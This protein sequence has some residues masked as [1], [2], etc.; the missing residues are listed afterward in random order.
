MSVFSDF[1]WRLLDRAVTILSLVVTQFAFVRLLS[2]ENYGALSYT[3]AIVAL[4]A[5]IAKLGA[6]GVVTKALLAEPAEADR[7]LGAAMAWRLI[8]GLTSVLVVL[9][10]LAVFPADSG[11][12]CVV[13]LAVSQALTLHTVLDFHFDAKSSFGRLAPCRLAITVLFTITK[14]LAVLIKPDVLTLTFV[15]AIE[16]LIGSVTSAW[17][18]RHI[19]GYYVKLRFDKGALQ[20]LWSRASWIAAAGVAE[21]IYLKIDVL[22][23]GDVH[24]LTEVAVYSAAARVS[25]A[26]YLVP[27][28]LMTSIYPVWWRARGNAGKW[29]RRTERIA[30]LLGFFGLVCASVLSLVVAPLLPALFGDDYA[31][32]ATVLIVHA[33]AAPFIFMR[34]V[35]S[36]WVIAEDILRFSLMT[37]AI[38]ALLNI[39]LNTFLI[40]VYGATGAAVATV[41]SYAAASWLSLYVFA[42]TRLFANMLWRSLMCSFAIRNHRWFWRWIRYRVGGSERQRANQ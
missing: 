40:P 38:G 12:L 23:L 41:L 8:G 19:V 18:H 11:F 24:G 27:A 21:A 32:S 13:L 6:G 7:L 35:F 42:E 39:G 31:R 28:M 20:W 17:L 36:R 14:V 5:P 34:V 1:R 29:N 4:V 2:A 16:L 22:M 10:L 33:W 37:T 15:Y 3:L 30:S 25:E 9:S 26:T